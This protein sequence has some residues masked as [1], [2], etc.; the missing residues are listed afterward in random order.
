MKNLI[1]RQRVEDRVNNG[2]IYKEP[3]TKIVTELKETSSDKIILTGSRFSGKSTVL[4]EMQKEDA[5]TMNPS[6]I[7]H[8]EGASHFYG[9]IDEVFTKEFFR[10]KYELEMADKILIFIK[11]YYE[12]LYYNCFLETDKKILKMFNELN[13][14]IRNAYYKDVK[15]EKLLSFGELTE[16]IIKTF[17]GKLPVET[18]TL[19][20]DRFDWINNS[21]EMSQQMLSDYFSLFDKTIITSDDKTILENSRKL[22]LNQKGYE[23]KEV[24]YGENF[25]IIKEIL[26]LFITT[27]NNNLENGD[28]PFLQS[29][30]T[31]ELLIEAQS[32]SKGNIQM[33]L[34]ATDYAH[35]LYSY[36]IF[37]KR[38]FEE[39]FMKRIEEI[40]NKRSEIEKM[41]RV[42][43]LY[44]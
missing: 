23:I 22:D 19:I 43:K 16:K 13:N 1:K 4:Y 29:Y 28:K 3:V 25:E 8:F 12:K 10:H 11:K 30:L 9:A 39:L 37:E 35:D 41:S 42:K 14:Y 38:S 31:N 15:I 44:L 24:N 18:I 20:L 36:P 21:H 6:I 7:C 17:K 27:Y 5:T 26:N 40:I 33:I 32:L 34:E 2:E